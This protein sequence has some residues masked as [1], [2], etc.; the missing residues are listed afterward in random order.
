ME[1]RVTF[2]KLVEVEGG[3]TFA[4]NIA[5]TAFEVPALITSNLT[6]SDIGG[7]TLSVSGN[8]LLESITT[9]HISMFEGTVEI[10]NNARLSWLLFEN[11]TEI[12]SSFKISNNNR[13]EGLQFSA[14]DK[15][16]R[17]AAV[18]VTSNTVMKEVSFPAL[19][20]T[21]GN[22]TVTISSNT[23][24]KELSFPVLVEITSARFAGSFPA[25]DQAGSV[26]H[27]YACLLPTYTPQFS[28]LHNTHMSNGKFCD[29]ITRRNHAG[30]PQ[31]AARRILWGFFHLFWRSVPCA[32]KFRYL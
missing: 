14:L 16:T 27:A 21:L 23:V 9:E 8:E 13:L 7:H 26:N 25:L 20:S 10:S 17:T 6:V 4:S 19:I 18:A 1:G 11:L 24:L 30:D 28:M 22:S 12:T 32:A 2:A 29:G 15:V 5:A 3:I 31:T